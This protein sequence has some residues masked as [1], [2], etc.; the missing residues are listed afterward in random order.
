M[1]EG[2]SPMHDAFPTTQRTW[3]VETLRVALASRDPEVRERSLAELRAHVMR[4]YFEPLRIYVKGSS[5]RVMG[6][7]ADLVNG[8]FASRLSRDDYLARWVESA[9]PLRRWLA[10][11]LVMHLRERSRE[12]RIGGRPL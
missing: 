5:F 7:S 8:F 11:G 9:L 2:R 1:A 6:E 3:I 12:G 10:N 4:T